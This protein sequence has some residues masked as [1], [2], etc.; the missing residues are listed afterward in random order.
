MAK[1]V[2][3]WSVSSTLEGSKS[4]S[5]LTWFGR[6]DHQ[7]LNTGKS[8]LEIRTTHWLVS[9]VKTR[10]CFRKDETVRSLLHWESR[11]LGA[12]KVVILTVWPY[13]SI[14]MLAR[15]D[16]LLWSSIGAPFCGSTTYQFSITNWEDFV[17]PCVRR[18]LLIL[19]RWLNLRPSTACMPLTTLII[20]P[21]VLGLQS[22]LWKPM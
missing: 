10:R 12:F 4:I 13:S 17:I 21:P 14:L 15:Y 3:G 6:S 8:G 11:R 22:G 2:W 5:W 16:P 19:I 9:S 20:H 18:E 7:K 1:P